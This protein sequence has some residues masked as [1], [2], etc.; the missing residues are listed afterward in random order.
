MNELSNARKFKMRYMR[1]FIDYYLIYIHIITAKMVW[2]ETRDAW[3]RIFEFPMK[4]LYFLLNYK[5]TTFHFL[6]FIFILDTQSNQWNR[7][8]NVHK[9]SSEYNVQMSMVYVLLCP[10]FSNFRI[11]Q[12]NYSLNVNAYKSPISCNVS[13]KHRT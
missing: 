10:V 7:P 1:Y 6:F 8:H 2:P 13:R 3:N 12:M 9:F 11:M 5:I 4:R